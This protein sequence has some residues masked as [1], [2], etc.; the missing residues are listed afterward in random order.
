MLFALYILALVSAEALF[1][2]VAAAS[3]LT[4]PPPDGISLAAALAVLASISVGLAI[5]RAYQRRRRRR[6]DADL[7]PVKISY[8]LATGLS[9]AAVDLC[10]REF[11]RFFALICKGQRLGLPA[12][13]VDGVWR[14]LVAHSDIYQRYSDKVHG[15]LIAYD[16]GEVVTVGSGDEAYGLTLACYRRRWRVPPA[17]IWP[18]LS[19][20]DTTPP[21]PPLPAKDESLAFARQAVRP[22]PELAA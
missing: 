20:V 11:E 19:A 22:S 7:A 14:E 15:R 6:I 17:E 12:G 10:F 9:P 8:E 5:G 4:T 16:G 1:L 21:T 2:L 18:P 3:A 13:H